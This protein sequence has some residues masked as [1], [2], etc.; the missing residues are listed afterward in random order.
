MPCTPLALN[1]CKSTTFQKACII[2]SGGGIFPPSTGT[3][4]RAFSIVVASDM[5][6]LHSVRMITDDLQDAGIV[7]DFNNDQTDQTPCA[8]VSQDSDLATTWTFLE[9]GVD[10]MLGP[11]HHHLAVGSS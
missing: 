5:A 9:E 7:V 10:H 6:A 2:I 4:A 11:P 8:T 1:S 3:L